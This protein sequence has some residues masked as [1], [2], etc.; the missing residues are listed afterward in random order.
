[1]WMP[2]TS[3]MAKLVKVR[4]SSRFREGFCPLPPIPQNKVENKKENN[5][6]FNNNHHTHF[7]AQPYMSNFDIQIHI[8]TCKHTICMCVYIH[9]KEQQQQ[10]G[11]VPKI[12]KISPHWCQVGFVISLY[13]C[14]M[15]FFW[16]GGLSRQGGPDH[17]GTCS[18]DQFCYHIIKLASN[19][20][21]SSCF[22]LPNAIL[23]C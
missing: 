8:H 15:F 13:A 10:K 9:M 2:R 22:C 4:E 1:M 16:G 6:N 21:I 18:V 3:W 5:N 23:V 20:Q 17:P 19:S 12:K 7:H 14:F 11:K